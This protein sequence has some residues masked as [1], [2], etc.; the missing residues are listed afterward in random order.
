MTRIAKIK[1]KLMPALLLLFLACANKTIIIKSRVNLP[2]DEAIEILRKLRGQGEKLR[3][4]K[5]KGDVKIDSRKERIVF[6]EFILLKRPMQIYMTA[7]KFGTPVI[8]ISINGK[9]AAVYDPR[10]NE[11]YLGEVFD[12]DGTDKL[13]G[14]ELKL[15]DLE[16]ALFGGPYIPPEYTLKEADL[17]NNLYQ[18][19]SV[20]AGPGNSEVREYWIDSRSKRCFLVKIFNGNTPQGISVGFSDFKRLKENVFPFTINLKRDEPYLTMSIKVK[21][22]YPNTEIDPKNLKIE[23]PKGVVPKPIENMLS[24]F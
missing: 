23:I 8:Y 24:G 10:G 12:S 20:S 11:F 4:I 1:I 6:K 9:I 19:I 2:K 22:V 3:S 21:E 14:I 18:R 17:I 16:E 15:E 5:I 13:I 7:V